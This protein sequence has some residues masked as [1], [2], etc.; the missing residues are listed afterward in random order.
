MKLPFLACFIISFLSACGD[1]GSDASND[2]GNVSSGNNDNDNPSSATE[3]SLSGSAVKG[4]LAQAQI[5]I[6]AMDL[7]TASAKGNL[8][9]RGTTND[10]AQIVD[11][12]LTGELS[13]WYLIEYSI[14]DN[15]IDI[16]TGVS[17]IF[18]EL[19]SAVNAAHIESAKPLYATPLTTMAVNLA[20]D[21]AD[22]GSP[23]SGNGDETISEPEFAS[24]LLLAEAQV[25]SV[26]GFGIG[27]DVS[28]FE[29]P[30][31]ITEDTDSIQEQTEVAE[32]RLAIE[33]VAAIASSVSENSSAEESAEDILEALTLD[34]ADGSIDGQG[35][36]GAVP[37]LEQLDQSI[38]MAIT[39]LD[40]DALLVPGTETALTD[41]EALLIDELLTTNVSADVTLL[42][43]G[44]INVEPSEIVLDA[45]ADADGVADEDDA[46][47]LDPQET[48]DSDEDGV[49][50]NGDAFPN[51]P[52]EIADSDD[53]QVG[54]NADAFPNAPEESVDSDEDGVGNNSDDFPND[55]SETTDSDNDQVGD[56]ADAFPNDPSE[57]TDSDNDQVGDNSDAFPSDPSESMDSDEDGVGDNADAY[58]DDPT[59]SELEMLNLSL[60][61]GEND[62]L[63]YYP[64]T[65]SGIEHYRSSEPA[66]DIT[67][68]SVCENGALN[69][70]NGSD[71][72][73]EL[74]TRTQ[75]GFH[76]FITATRSGELDVTGA[77]RWVHR[78]S[79]ATATFN[80]R[81]WVI[82]GWDGVHD[83][84]ENGDV[85]E[86]DV[87]SGSNAGFDGFLANDVWSSQDGNTW[88]RVV[89]NTEFSVR[90]E[91][92]V[93]AFNDKLWLIGGTTYNTSTTLN[94][95]L[96]DVW[97]S[98]DGKTWVQEL[99]NA[100]FAV[101]RDHALL[102]HNNRMWVIGGT[103]ADFESLNDVW[104]SDNGTEWIQATDD[105]GFPGQ[106]Y[107]R[108]ISKD[109]KLMLI[110]G[111]GLYEGVWS[112]SD[113]VE[114]LQEA[115][116]NFPARNVYSVT[117][118]N[119]K[120]WVAGGYNGGYLRDVWV[121]DDG[122]SYTEVER[123]DGIY[124][125]NRAE[126]GFLS[127]NDKLW[128]IGGRSSTRY[129]EVLSSDDGSTWLRNSF[130]PK[131]MPQRTAGELIAF[132]DQLFVFAGTTYENDNGVWSTEDGINWTELETQNMFDARSDTES[133][134]LGEKLYVYG[135]LVKYDGE[136]PQHLAND[137]WSTEDGSTWLQETASA[138][139]SE[140]YR[141]R[142]IEWNGALWM[143]G[144]ISNSNTYLNDVWSSTDG[145]NWTLVTENAAFPERGGHSMFILNDRLWVMG[146]RGSSIL[147]KREDVWSTANGVDW[148]E[149]SVVTPEVFRPFDRGVR[150][151]YEAAVYNDRIYLI[152]GN[153]SGEELQDIWSSADG[154]SWT[155]DV[156]DAG[157]LARRNYSTEV[158]KGE[159]WL[160]GGYHHDS[161]AYYQ[162]D[163]WRSN[164]G[165]N[166]RVGLKAEIPLVENNRP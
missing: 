97:S 88:T 17:P 120:V 129:G 145:V 138:A 102:V 122:L 19:I 30:P 1:G 40:L 121:S 41:I 23:Y 28:L 24:A 14:T 94:E 48:I 132:N 58:P 135:G 156:E 133:A 73:D 12:S 79:F 157:P 7:S 154:A 164:D 68:Y 78:Q 62:T 118:H 119:N 66:C 137:I 89:Q 134:V 144:G 105:A 140:R 31:L 146:G 32:Y 136:T 54:D 11:L 83:G 27:D 106:S 99:E 139:F 18:N 111:G 85:S 161:I 125:Q 87:N 152:G 91:H 55:P 5:S 84:V 34:L 74:S 71:L 149:T 117:V 65:A 72:S 20:L 52:T 143:T 39:N 116:T 142:V 37:V 131:E 90:Q 141:H 2:N 51:D 114:W 57:T 148:V 33:A 10:Q 130:G 13:G 109:G 153:D 47:P 82:G 29:T 124:F 4:P 50:D 150:E 123:A 38:D 56:N 162:R 6:Y 45:D 98:E 35:S 107:P 155:L 25:K 159:L 93:V 22:K 86:D 163:L 26:F 21:R 53:D 128:L 77:E 95:A 112:S 100:P 36:E 63:I 15:T 75:A 8:L 151:N 69:I 110:G 16:N 166:W 67:N 158:Y 113:G 70:I 160:H 108:V 3:F 80:G 59:R 9:A 92:K 46:F 81:M 126:P 101:R 42:E 76:Q 96:N 60:W 61:V 165:I 115:D 44:S 64:E 147:D 127:F 49:G 103:A 43:D 104:Y